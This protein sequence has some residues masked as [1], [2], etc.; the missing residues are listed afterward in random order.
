MNHKIKVML[1]ISGILLV[2]FLFFNSMGDAS[3]THHKVHKIENPIRK[4]AEKQIRNTFGYGDATKI[5]LTKA[6]LETSSDLLGSSI[7]VSGLYHSKP[8]SITLV[9]D[10]LPIQDKAKQEITI[11][12]YNKDKYYSKDQGHLDY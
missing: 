5:V 2:S 1:T 10:E 4:H 12:R 11:Y 3:Q 8:L 9:D 7:K 6:T